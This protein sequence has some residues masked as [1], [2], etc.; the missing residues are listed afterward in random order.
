LPLDLAIALLTDSQGKINA[1][2]PVEGDLDHL[3]FGYGKLIWQAIDT[4]VFG[5][6]RYW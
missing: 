5:T 2:V 6:I 1:S 4:Y 3:E